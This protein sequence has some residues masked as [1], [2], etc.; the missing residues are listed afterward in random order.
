M[1]RMTGL[2]AAFLSMESEGHPMHTLKLLVLE[3]LPGARP[4]PLSASL[5]A[6]LRERLHLLPALRRRALEVPHG[7]H[8]PLW[9]EERDPD[10]AP[11]LHSL[12]LPAPGGAAELDALIAQIA[13]VP[14]DRARP[15]WE[16]WALEGLEGGASAVLVK[17]HHAL[18]D[19]LT[20]AQLLRRVMTAEPSD[21][22]PAS[23]DGNDR[24]PSLRDA[25]D[26]PPSDPP[27]RV[28]LVRGALF[29][30][31]R[32]LDTLLP[33]LRLTGERLRALRRHRR[34]ST[35]RAPLP[36]RDT[37][38]TSF[39]RALGSARSFA[40]TTL[41]LSA[42][43]A[44]KHARGVTLNDVFLALV[45]GSLR[46]YL[47]ARGEL[48]PRPLIASVPTAAEHPPTVHGGNHV[49]SL[50]VSLQ[51]HLEDPLER[52]AAISRSAEAA[53]GS[54]RAIGSDLME[55]WAAFVPPR[56]LGGAIAAYCRLGLADHVPAPLNLIASSVPGPGA[57]LYVPGH[58]LRAIYSVGPLLEGIGLNVT[59]WSYLGAL[60]VAV[61]ADRDAMPAPRRLTE[62]MHRALEALATA[63]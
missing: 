45:A 44:I 61:L 6:G 41:P 25:S 13:A 33:L 31:R 32:Q 56:V 12:V 53:K 58:R 30:H 60:H 7:L 46:E 16:M 49:S 47:V 40:S 8:H 4:R 55:R 27:D 35:A 34:A 15:L 19:G 59:A 50:F 29:D 38:R 21:A 10:L 28:E 62:G 54:Q 2:D 24:G 51:T 42:L 39:N 26:A 14:L 18:A 37:P 48:P 23:S 43:A 52:L 11:H 36:L 57:P 1:E 3:P 22:V 17:I 20:V 63:T 5:E 9:I